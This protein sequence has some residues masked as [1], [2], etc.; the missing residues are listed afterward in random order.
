MPRFKVQLV[1]VKTNDTK[2]RVIAPKWGE[3][4][5]SNEEEYLGEIGK[6]AAIEQS[7]EEGSKSTI[8]QAVGLTEV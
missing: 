5:F 1:N 4:Y 8:Y 2:E 3:K 6:T 7:V